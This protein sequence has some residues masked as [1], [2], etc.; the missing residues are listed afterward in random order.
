MCSDFDIECLIEHW[1]F[2]C[3]PEKCAYFLPL[4]MI[5]KNS[6]DGLL[7]DLCIKHNKSNEIIRQ[8]GNFKTK[9]GFIEINC[10]SI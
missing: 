9:S 3:F 8:P 7:Y 2:L 1:R 10:R 6:L 4:L 5:R